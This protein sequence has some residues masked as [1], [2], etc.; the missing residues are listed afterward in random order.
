VNDSTRLEPV[1]LDDFEVELEENKAVCIQY[2]EK[3]NQGSYCM[4]GKVVEI[5]HIEPVN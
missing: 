2:Q 5:V 1:N 4:V 3:L